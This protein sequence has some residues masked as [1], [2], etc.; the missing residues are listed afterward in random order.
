M[1]KGSLKR[2][3]YNHK[4]NDS[5]ISVAEQHAATPRN[6]MDSSAFVENESSNAPLA[7]SGD[8]STIK[9]STRS[10]RNSSSL[11]GGDITILK[12]AIHV[13]PHLG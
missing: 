6:N 4:Y 13:E 10:K 2:N 1:E 12:S 5:E 11:S 8:E 9:T 3:D 7:P